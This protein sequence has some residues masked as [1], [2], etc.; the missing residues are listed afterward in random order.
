M[1]LT[2]E[3]ISVSI[4]YRMNKQNM[5]YPYNRIQLKKNPSKNMKESQKHYTK[6]KKPDTKD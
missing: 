5:V 6:R 3:K 1:S 2:L 4:N